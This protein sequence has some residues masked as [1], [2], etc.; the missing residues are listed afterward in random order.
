MLITMSISCAPARIA[1]RVSNTFA[2][3]AAAPSG[4]P[5]TAI[6]FVGHPASRRAASAT[7]EELRQTVANP[8]LRASSH[9]LITSSRVASG[10]SKVWSMTP[11]RS[12]L[13]R[14]ASGEK[15]VAPRSAIARAPHEPTSGHGAQPSG[16][17][18]L[19]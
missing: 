12:R 6:G 3:V 16:A 5:T 10:L 1:S 8:Y 4:K 18:S 2:L 13:V 9:S 14:I 11:A 7:F 17:H 15:R 19:G